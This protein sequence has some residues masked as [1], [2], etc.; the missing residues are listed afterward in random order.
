MHKNV[1]LVFGKI[2]LLQNVVA[3]SRIIVFNI[4][5]RN[6]KYLSKLNNFQ[7]FCQLI[8]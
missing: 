3:Q 6:A 8:Y 7:Y 5:V 1:L 2:T 4:F